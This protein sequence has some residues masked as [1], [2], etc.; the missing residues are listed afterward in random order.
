MLTVSDVVAEF[1][2]LRNA[3]AV[4]RVAKSGALPSWKIAGRVVFSRAD[5]EAY[6]AGCY[7]SRV[8]AGKG[9]K[10]ESKLVIAG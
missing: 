7:R 10:F 9:R 3:S 4:Y 1:P 8:G 5:V 2:A 6:L